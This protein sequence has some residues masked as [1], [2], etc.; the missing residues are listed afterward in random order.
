[1]GSW[2]VAGGAWTRLP[3]SIPMRT[4]TS[5]QNPVVARFRALA[6]A[7]DATGAR[8]LLDGVHLVRDAQESGHTFEI[9]A[10]SSSRLVSDNEEAQ[11]AERLVKSG[12]EVIQAPDAVFAAMSP[13]RT[14]SGIVAIASRRPTSASEICGVEDAL[15]LVAI[16]VQDPGNVGA[17]VRTGEAGGMTGMFVCGASANPFSWKAVRGSMGSVLRVPIVAGM[18]TAS[19]MTCLRSGGIRTVAAVPRGGEDPDTIDWRGRV[20]LIVGGEGGGVPDE[21]TQSCIAVVSIPMAARV[22]SLNVAA[23]GA[24]LVY[25]ARRQRR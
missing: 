3:P 22:E 11:M 5:R 23:A 19:V 12:V 13:V 25:A 16:D 4:V 18:T 6:D 10:V 17:L 21:I 7:A 24:I 14:P 8:V 1:M 20:A 2:I 9:A 15:I